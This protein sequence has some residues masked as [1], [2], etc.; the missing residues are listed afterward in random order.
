MRGVKPSL[1]FFP[2]NKIKMTNKKFTEEER[3]QMLIENYDKIKKDFEEKIVE[4]IEECKIYREVFIRK[5]ELITKL[6]VAFPEK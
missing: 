4:I 5:K 1:K 2:K 6:E 3:K